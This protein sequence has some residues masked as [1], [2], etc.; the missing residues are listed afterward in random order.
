MQGKHARTNLIVIRALKP[1][2][3]SPRACP[4]VAEHGSRHGRR[5][6]THGRGALALRPTAPD[7]GTESALLLEV[8]PPL[9]R[10]LAAVELAVLVVPAFVG[11]C[12]CSCRLSSVAPTKVVE[13]P[14][15][16][17]GEDEVPNWQG[18]EIDQHPR[19][20]DESMC[21]DDDKDTG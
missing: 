21:G 15:R 1:P 7:R 18:E 14:E 19:Y 5:A 4:R 16:V 3:A 6:S 17:C 12:D 2:R 11:A 20:V 10:D 9:H 13:V 8:A